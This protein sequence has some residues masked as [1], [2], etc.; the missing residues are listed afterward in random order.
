MIFP[1]LLKLVAAIC[2]IDRP[3]FHV[4]NGIGDA[5]GCSVTRPVQ[6]CPEDRLFA[7]RS[8]RIAWGS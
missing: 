6:G 2:S 8:C 1:E 5:L 4:T 3:F 7:G